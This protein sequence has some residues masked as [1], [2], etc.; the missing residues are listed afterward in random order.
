MST[1]RDRI[2]CY[3]C[4]EYD[5]F[6]KDCPTFKEEREIRQIKEMFNLDEV[7]T[8]LKKLATNTYATL[9]KINIASVNESKENKYLTEE[10]ATHVYKKMESSNIINTNTLKEEI[11]QD[12]KLNKLE[13]TSGDINPYR[14]LI[15][16]NAEKIETVYH[17]WNNGLY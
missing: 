13:D 1:N 14:E 7:Q 6:T 5:H 8:S 15:V 9:Y 2:R 10:Q 4:R 11:D 17:R 12:R 3:K 16:S